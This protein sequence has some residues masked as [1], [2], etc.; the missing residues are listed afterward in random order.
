MTPEERAYRDV[1]GWWVDERRRSER[2]LDVIHGLARR[3][4]AYRRL[5]ADVSREVAG[6]REEVDQLR[7][8]VRDAWEDANRV[9]R[10]RG[11]PPLPAACPDC[12]APLGE[13]HDPTCAYG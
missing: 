5:H 7:V 8:A 4:R 13:P 2:R 1:W 9:R 6:L 11:Q 12:G 3:L 10:L